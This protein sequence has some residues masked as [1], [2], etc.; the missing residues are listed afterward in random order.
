[1]PTKLKKIKSGKTCAKCG[2]RN[3]FAAMC[4]ADE[5]QGSKDRSK[6]NELEYEDTEE[7]DINCDPG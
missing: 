4:K 1:M 3:H 5:Q 7:R 6:V 2:R